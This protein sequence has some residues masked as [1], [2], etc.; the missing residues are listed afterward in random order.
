MKTCSKCKVEKDE[1]EFS[2]QTSN[3]DGLNYRCK[4]CMREYQQTD[5]YK[6]YLKARQQTDARKAYLKAH[7]QTDAYKASLIAYQQTDTYKEYQKAYK[8]RKA[9]AAS[10]P[11]NACSSGKTT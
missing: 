1:A 5:A 9:L 2:K 10:L 3:K 8:K 6:A 11:G 7:R 4:S